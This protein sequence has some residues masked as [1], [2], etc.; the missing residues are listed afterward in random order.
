MFPAV[1]SPTVATVVA[2]SDNLPITALFDN[3]AAVLDTLFAV[4]IATFDCKAEPATDTAPLMPAVETFCSAL[5]PASVLRMAVPDAVSIARKP[6]VEI[7]LA[8]V[9]PDVAVVDTALTPAEAMP[10]N[11]ALVL[12]VD[13]VALSD[14]LI[15][16]VVALLLCVRPKSV[17]ARI[18]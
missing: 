18:E 9:S 5:Y 12:C 6:D 15:P 14:C 1:V 13:A 4:T 17:C 2:L 11:A 16:R 10:K 8:V 7:A 3:V